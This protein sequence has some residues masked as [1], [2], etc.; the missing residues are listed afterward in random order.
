M[1]G[2]GYGALGAPTQEAYNF[3]LEWAQALFFGSYEV[4]TGVKPIRDLTFLQ[5]RSVNL[6]FP[7]FSP[8]LACFGPFYFI[9]FS[10]NSKPFNLTVLRTTLSHH[11]NV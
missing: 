9:F 10:L 2:S 7:S 4:R 6:V 8:P 3:R 5:E 11:I 1:I